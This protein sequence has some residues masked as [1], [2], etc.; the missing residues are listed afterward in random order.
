MTYVVR[1]HVTRIN[2]EIIKA[3]KARKMIGKPNW[4][5]Q[6]SSFLSCS[7]GIFL[8]VKLGKL[9]IDLK[10]RIWK[11]QIC[12]KEKYFFSDIIWLS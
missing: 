11:I 12:Q 10:L 9:Y 6:L 5:I 8:T 1:Y 3:Q 7:G 4:A 2:S